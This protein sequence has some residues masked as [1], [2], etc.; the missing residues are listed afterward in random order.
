MYVC[1][2]CLRRQR[3]CNTASSKHLQH[4]QSAQFYF[5]QPSQVYEAYY[6]WMET[7]MRA[8]VIARLASI[9]HQEAV[10]IVNVVSAFNELGG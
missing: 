7:G 9:T 5:I 8:Q 4:F 6:H 10:G 1:H 2:N 3:F